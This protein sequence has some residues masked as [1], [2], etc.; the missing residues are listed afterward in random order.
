MG[1][2][3]DFCS[4][5][6]PVGAVEKLFK[7]QSLRGGGGHGGDHNESETKPNQKLTVTNVGE[8]W[9]GHGWL[10]CWDGSVHTILKVVANE[11][12]N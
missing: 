12:L 9:N 2:I 4:E 6:R 7:R 5:R 3:G 10:G 8:G 1:P 11:C